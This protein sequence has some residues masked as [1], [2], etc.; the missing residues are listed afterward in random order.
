MLLV[1]NI[2]LVLPV[3]FGEFCRLEK[4]KKIY[5]KVKNI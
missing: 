5:G 2:L 1:S 3:L 4:E